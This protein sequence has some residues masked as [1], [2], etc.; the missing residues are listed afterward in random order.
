MRSI[1]SPRVAFDRRVVSVED[2]KLIPIDI[3]IVLA[4]IDAVLAPQWLGNR[5]AEPATPQSYDRRAI[6]E[7]GRIVRRKGGVGPVPVNDRGVDDR[8]VTRSGVLGSMEIVCSSTIT[9][10]S[11]KETSLPAD[12]AR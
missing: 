5:H 3:N 1:M 7:N 9:V 10:A 12:C 8:D 6:G 2:N 4:P 11:G